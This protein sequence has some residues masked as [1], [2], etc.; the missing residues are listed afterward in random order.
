[1]GADDCTGQQKAAAVAVELAF[2]PAG[3]CDEHRLAREREQNDHEHVPIVD[4]ANASDVVLP[5][6]S[7]GPAQS[8]PVHA[9]GELASCASGVEE[10]EVRSVSPPPKLRSRQCAAS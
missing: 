1:M 5:S 9:V 4:E 2:D 8:S 6:T 7:G 10:P 3:L